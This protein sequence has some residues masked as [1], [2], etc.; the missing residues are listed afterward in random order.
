MKKKKFIIILATTL[1]LA[2]LYFVIFDVLRCQIF[3]EE[4]PN[5]GYQIVSLWIDKG[6]FGYGG[7]HYIKKKGFFSKWHMIEKVPSAC[8]WISETQFTIDRPYP[9]ED[10][11]CDVKDFFDK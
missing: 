10:K 1:V 3:V 11:K 8:E 2:M 9:N 6:A 5:G 7:A 4:S